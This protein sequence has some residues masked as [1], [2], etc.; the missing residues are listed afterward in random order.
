MV[1]VKGDEESRDSNTATD[2]LHAP[3]FVRYHM[4]M[5]TYDWIIH[6]LFADTFKIHEAVPICQE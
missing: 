3:V 2:L 5:Y 6:L 1:P 4:R